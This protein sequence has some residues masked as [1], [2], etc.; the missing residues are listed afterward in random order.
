MPYK[1][2][3]NS[4]DPGYSGNRSMLLKVFNEFVAGCSASFPV[5][6]KFTSDHLM[7]QKYLHIR[8]RPIIGFT[9]LFNRYR[10][11]LIGID[12]HHIGIGKIGIGMV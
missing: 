9:D 10:Y 11:Q 12:T 3:L 1:K 6:E 5:A 2:C 7:M 4:L 8:D